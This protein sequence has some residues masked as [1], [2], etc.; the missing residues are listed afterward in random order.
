VTVEVGSTLPTVVT[1]VRKPYWPLTIVPRVGE[2][3][4]L[5]QALSNTTPLR[6]SASMFGIDTW[7]RVPPRSG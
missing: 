3:T 6:A 7:P 1:P 4:G 2:H 5:A